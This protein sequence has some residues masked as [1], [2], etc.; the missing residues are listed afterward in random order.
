[1]ASGTPGHNPT[2]TISLDDM[3]SPVDTVKA[4]AF[5][6]E[7]LQIEAA[8]KQ[9]R[10]HKP[11]TMNDTHPTSRPKGVK[12]L[13]DAVINSSPSGPK[14]PLRLEMRQHTIPT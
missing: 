8:L 2:P 12:T 10:S 3:L 4:T 14:S 1:M 7:H 6:A 11:S 13:D 9:V 5:F